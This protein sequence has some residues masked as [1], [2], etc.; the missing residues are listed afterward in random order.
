VRFAA[1]N[2]SNSLKN[3]AKDL[4]GDNLQTLN[5]ANSQFIIS[6]FACLLSFCISLLI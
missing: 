1:N 4:R 6:D 5:S 2:V 3:I